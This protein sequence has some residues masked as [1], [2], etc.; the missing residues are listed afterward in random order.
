MIR[1]VTLDEAFCDICDTWASPHG[2]AGCGTHHCYTCQERNGTKYS[3]SVWSDSGG[4]YYCRNCDILMRENP[5]VIERAYLTVWHLKQ[6]SDAFYKP[7]N[8]RR[9]LAELEVERLR[10]AEQEDAK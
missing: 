6:E 2:C 8:E 10:C 3:A 1:Q 9:K 7:W 4:R 5:T